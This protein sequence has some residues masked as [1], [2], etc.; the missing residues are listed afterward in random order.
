M[1][2]NSWENEV[3]FVK[4]WIGSGLMAW[5]RQLVGPSDPNVVSRPQTPRPI[6]FLRFHIL[7]DSSQ[8]SWENEDLILEIGASVPDLWLGSLLGQSRRGAVSRVQTPTSINFLRFMIV[9]NSSH[10]F[11]E[12]EVLFV[13]IG[14]RLLDSWLDTS[15]GC[16]WSKCSF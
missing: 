2:K 3:L 7:L 16:K 1:T 6:I 5:L 9:L 14:A 15:S 13:K 12:N 8:D 11:W 4:I 10:D